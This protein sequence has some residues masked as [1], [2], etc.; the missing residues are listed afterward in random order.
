MSENDQN[1]PNNTTEQLLDDS[2][3]VERLNETHIVQNIS[4]DYRDSNPSFMPKDEE[5]II[6]D[7]ETKQV[8]ESK[9]HLVKP[10]REKLARL[11]KIRKYNF[12]KRIFHTMEPGSL[13]KGVLLMIRMTV[14]VGILTLPHYVSVFGC[15]V[16]VLMIALAGIVNYLVYAFI[17]EVSNETGIYD[18]VLLTK[19]YCNKV[20]RSIFRYSYLLDLMSLPILVYIMTWN[21]LEYLIAFSGLAND[22]WYSDKETLTF[23][24][25]HPTILGIRAAYCVVSFVL[26]LG[27]L[28]K[29]DL[30][31]LQI[32]GNIFLVFLLL[33]LVVI[34]TEMGFFRRNLRDLPDF[35]VTY[36]SKMPTIKWIECF[37][38]VMLSF[39]CQPYYFSI[40]NELMHP[41]KKRLKKMIGLS[42]GTIS[43]FFMLIGFVCYYCLGDKFTPSLVILR[44][45]YEGKPKWSEYIFQIAIL[46]F[47]LV[48]ILSMPLFNPPIR[49]Y[50]MVEFKFDGPRA[51]FYYK[52][53]SVLPFLIAALICFVYPSIIGVFNFF[54]TTV[55]NFNG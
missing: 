25:Y 43:F 50:I 32:V 24:E 35:T 37:F 47:F 16:G 7:P 30:G 12:F 11:L 52:L 26:I 46:L 13:R 20:V 21:V 18:Y 31:S 48:S 33:L 15:L 14:G 53:W 4:M 45:A 55:F 49:D 38:S 9:P 28:F 44:K 1:D 41:T 29:K 5:V 8:V 10:S 6:F 3:Q 39:Y 22:D 34:L 36:I 27:L 40:R 51:R 54:S 42:I 17:A 23:N 19:R 2:I